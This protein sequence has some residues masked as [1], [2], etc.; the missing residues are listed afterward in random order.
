LKSRSDVIVVGYIAEEDKD[1][2]GQLELLAKTMHPEYV[3]GIINDSMLAEFECIN[4]PGVAVYRISN[5]EKTNLPLVR[6]MDKMV[7]YL[8][9]TARPLIVDLAFE[10]LEGLLDVSRERTKTQS[11]PRTLTNRLL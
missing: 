8:R 4:M 9:K 7:A 6:D 11:Y 3:F 1:S 10:L 5:G 2:K